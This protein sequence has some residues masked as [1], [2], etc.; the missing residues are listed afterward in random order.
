M[1]LTI[2]P[3]LHPLSYLKNYVLNF[4]LKFH[5]CIHSILDPVYSSHSPDNS[6]TRSSY[7]ISPP[8][9]P[10]HL[11][12]NSLNPVSA[13]HMCTVRGKPTGH[14]KPTRATHSNESD[15]SS[16][17]RSMSSRPVLHTVLTLLASLK[18]CFCVCQWHVCVSLEEQE[19]L[20]LQSPLSS[21]FLLVFDPCCSFPECC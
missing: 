4:S 13:A 9:L 21:P 15:T 18:N 6:P 1:F 17:M 12:L 5:A 14:G 20:E 2:E 7:L 11:L 3:S 10:I 16:A 19:C 8:T